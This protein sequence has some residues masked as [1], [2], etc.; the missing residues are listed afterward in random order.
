VLNYHLRRTAV[1]YGVPLLTNPNLVAMFA[2][3]MTAHAHKPFVGLSPE[4]LFDHYRA[5]KPSDAW[6]AP[7][8]FH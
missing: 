2:N 8:E 6:T 7:S 4:S 3:A 5:E 1:D